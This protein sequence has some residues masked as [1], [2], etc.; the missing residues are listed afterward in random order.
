MLR[1]LSV[2]GC[3]EDAFL[4]DRSEEGA[5]LFPVVTAHVP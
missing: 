2:E 5:R 4:E 1:V 3:L